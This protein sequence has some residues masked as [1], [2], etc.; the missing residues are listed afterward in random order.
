[1]C[2]SIMC[3]ISIINVLIGLLLN[4]IVLCTVYCGLSLDL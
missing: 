4:V 3:L 2:S 1:M